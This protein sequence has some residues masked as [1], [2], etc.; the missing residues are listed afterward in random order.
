LVIQVVVI[1]KA[2][3]EVTDDFPGALPLSE[4]LQID[5]VAHKEEVEEITDGADKQRKIEKEL[6]EISS[7]WQEQSF[8]FQEWK[9]RGIS[10][11]KGKRAMLMMS[12]TSMNDNR[13]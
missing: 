13:H 10:I 6:K 9:G 7:K 4:I 8:N 11:L 5:M 12:W 2:Q 3:V 1:C